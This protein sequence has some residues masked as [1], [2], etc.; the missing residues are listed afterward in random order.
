MAGSVNKA[1][2]LGRLGADP[3]LR[4]TPSGQSVANFNM[5]TNERVQREGSWEDRTEW[6]RIVVW[7]KLAERCDQYLNKG[8]QVY[9]EG[10][11][12][13]RKWQDREGTDRYTTEIVAF[14][15]QFLSTPSES[16]DRPP[17]PADTAEPAEPAAPAAPADKPGDGDGGDDDFP[18]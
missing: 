1:I 6:H 16:R 17:H 18:F 2:L 14:S 3:E 4:H 5:A 8:N 13:T 15:V 11:I 12:Q 9:V 7:G 10:R